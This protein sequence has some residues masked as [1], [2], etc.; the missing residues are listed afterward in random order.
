MKIWTVTSTDDL[1]TEPI[2]RCLTGSYTSRG[3]AL[4]ECVDY[5]MER[6]ENRDDFAYSMAHDENHED[7]AEF[8]SERRKDGVFVVKRGCA[9][10]LREY[11]RDELGCSSCYYVYDG[12]ESWHFDVDENDVVG[13]LWHTV[14]WGDSDCED[15]EFTTPWPEAF[16]SEETAVKTFVDYVRDLYKSHD[17][18]FTENVEKYIRGCLKAYGKC[19]VDLSDGCA[20]SCVIYHDDAVNIKE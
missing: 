12:N 11:L 7:V 9:R 4:D 18:A 3:K 8:F 13:E 14:T 10:K 20:V 5:I 1:R 17:M 19:Q 16:S 2:D 6:I 15:P